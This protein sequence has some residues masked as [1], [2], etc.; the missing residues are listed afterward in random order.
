MFIMVPKQIEKIKDPEERR[1]KMRN[2]IMNYG[3]PTGLFEDTS[4]KPKPKKKIKSLLRA[5]ESST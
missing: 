4:P 3:D 1:K 2:Y 5:R